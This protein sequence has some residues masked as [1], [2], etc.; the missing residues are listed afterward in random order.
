MTNYTQLSRRPK[1]FHAL[2]G[3]MLEEFRALLS[4]FVISFLAYVQA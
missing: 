2:T 1:Q 3:Y 4:A